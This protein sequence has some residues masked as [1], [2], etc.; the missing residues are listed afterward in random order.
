MRLAIVI[1]TYERPDG[2][3]K[4]LLIRALNSIYLQTHKDYKVYLIGDACPNDAMFKDIVSYYPNVTFTNLEKSV[5]REKYN[6]GTYE[7]WCAGGLTPRLIGINSALA[8]G[9]EYVCS[10]DHDDFWL[11]DHLATINDVIEKHNPNF[12]CTVSTY[13]GTKL[14]HVPLDGK[15]I[16]WSVF[17]GCCCNSASCVKYSET[18]LRVRDT[19]ALNGVASPPDADLWYRLGIEMKEKGQ[20]GYLVRK[21]TAHH[22]EE[23]YTMKVTKKRI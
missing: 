21:L 19:F 22:D 2:R 23:G 1:A 20:K 9:F 8:D 15:I 10:L 14:P 18:S 11:P 6:F 7:M 5:E 16:E 17:P 4:N 12:I 3:T 13:P